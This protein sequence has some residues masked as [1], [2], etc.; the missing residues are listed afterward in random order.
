MA[1]G[2]RSPVDAKRAQ[3][4]A[5][6]RALA[7]DLTSTELRVF[8]ALLKL[9]PLY[10]RLEDRVSNVQLQEATRITDE[11]RI[12][13]ATARLDELGVIEREAGGGRRPD[14][15][16]I[17]TLYR[18]PLTP[19][20]RVPGYEATGVR[21]AQV[22][23]YDDAVTPGPRAPASEVLSEAS[24]E[25]P[26]DPG[27]EGTGVLDHKTNAAMAAALRAELRAG[28]AAS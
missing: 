23:G 18:V 21:E 25:V 11:R 15:T 4:E 6:D 14:G 26:E 1:R 10:D 22:P 2:S 28:R 3:R 8:L 27:S 12:R 9:M 17:A 13:K 20:A 5:I 19:G 16:R 7:L 24:S